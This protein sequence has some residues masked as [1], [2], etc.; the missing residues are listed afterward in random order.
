MAPVIV[1]LKKRGIDVRVVDSGQHAT[2]TKSIREHFEL[3]EVNV[4][5]HRGSGA[6]TMGSG[7]KWLFQITKIGLQKNFDLLHKIFS[8]QTGPVLVHGDNLS[9]ALRVWLARRAGL[10]LAIVEAG[11][12]SN[13]PFHPFPEEILRIILPYAASLLFAPSER[14]VKNLRDMGVSGRIVCTGGNTIIDAMRIV[15]G[16]T[17]TETEDYGLWNFHRLETL[18]SPQRVDRLCRLMTEATEHGPVCFLVDLPTR[19]V[20]E[21]RGWLSRLRRVGVEILEIMPYPQFLNLL[22]RAKYVATDGGSIQEECAVLGV[23]C[24]VLRRCSERA[25]GLGENIVLERSVSIHDFLKDVE[26]YRKKTAWPNVSPSSKIV[27]ELVS[28]D[29]SAMTSIEE[30]PDFGK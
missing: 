13:N 26:F 2:V 25:D 24:M 17:F 18:F 15:L 6:L 19:P 27:D 29:F 10:P 3:D 21:R 8:G 14:E 12:R 30:S 16:N 7:L 28:Y 22:A 9:T 11:L 4:M 1:E 5:L 23:P 20:L